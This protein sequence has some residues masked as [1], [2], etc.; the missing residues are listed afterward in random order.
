MITQQFAKEIQCVPVLNLPAFG[1]KKAEEDVK[2][3]MSSTAGLWTQGDLQEQEMLTTSTNRLSKA[4]QL[5]VVAATTEQRR[6]YD[7]ITDLL[8][9]AHDCGKFSESGS[10]A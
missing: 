10:W 4:P 8:V 1:G 2:L 5:Q 6:E 7:F 9:L 3:H